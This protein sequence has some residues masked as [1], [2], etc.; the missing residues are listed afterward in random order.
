MKLAIL[1]LYAALGGV[2]HRRRLSTAL[3]KAGETRHWYYITEEY[4]PVCNTDQ[5]ERERIYGP[6]PANFWDRHWAVES[7]DGCEGY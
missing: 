7:Y 3:R 2:A 5:T 6:R 4:C 1:R